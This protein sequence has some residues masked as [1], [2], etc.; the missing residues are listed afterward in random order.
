MRG[1]SVMGSLTPFSRP[2]AATAAP[3]R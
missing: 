2:T 1:D 3:D